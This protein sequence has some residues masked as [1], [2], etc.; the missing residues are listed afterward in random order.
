MRRG[1]APSTAP[2][3][4]RRLADVAW[5]YG[6][7]VDP[8]TPPE[9]PGLDDGSAAALL[10]EAEDI[11]N[12]AGPTIRAEVEVEQDAATKPGMFKRLLPSQALSDARAGRRRE[13]LLRR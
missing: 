8:A 5:T 10:D 2:R 12:A 7:L 13:L 9:P 4:E 1:V 3:Y 11:L 6:S